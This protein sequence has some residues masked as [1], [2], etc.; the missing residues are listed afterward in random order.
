MNNYRYVAPGTSPMPVNAI[1]T[2]ITAC[3][4]PSNQD[5]NQPHRVLLSYVVAYIYYTLYE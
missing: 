2:E 3:V 4:R 5:V 1:W